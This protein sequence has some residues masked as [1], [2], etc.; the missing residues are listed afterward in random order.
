MQNWIS[1]FMVK[2]YSLSPDH[3]NKW[4]TGGRVDQ[5]IAESHLDPD[6]LL[7]G[8]KKFVQDR[9]KRLLFKSN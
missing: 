2:K 4:R 6:S 9:S 7:N 1:N 8:I 5:I 3:D